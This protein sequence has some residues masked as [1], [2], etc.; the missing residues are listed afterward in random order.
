MKYAQN[1]ILVPDHLPERI[2]T[3]HRQTAPPQLMT[4]TRLDQKTWSSL[5]GDQKVTLLDQL[6]QHYQGLS[7]QIKSEAT[8]KPANETTI[9]ENS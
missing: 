4:V 3:E 8:V 6:L 5:A 1:M 9:D 2:E 7:N